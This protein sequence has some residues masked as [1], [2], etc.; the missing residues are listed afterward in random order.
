[1]TKS[2][3]LADE[4]LEIFRMRACYILTYAYMQRQASE[5]R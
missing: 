3:Y 5:V 4:L 2:S 1:M